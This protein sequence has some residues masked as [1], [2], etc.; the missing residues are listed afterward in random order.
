MVPLPGNSKLVHTRYTSCDQ[1]VL[2]SQLASIAAIIDSMRKD[3]A[4]IKAQVIRDGR[5]SE[6]STSDLK[7]TVEN[8]IKET[9]TDEEQDTLKE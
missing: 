5:N 8:S 2:A 3:I 1:V 4:E 9:P 6:E 7:I